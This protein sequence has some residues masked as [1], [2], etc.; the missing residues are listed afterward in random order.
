MRTTR[1]RAEAR[2]QKLDAAL[3]EAKGVRRPRTSD[4][5]QVTN[6]KQIFVTRHLSLVT[7]LSFWLLTSVVSAQQLST[8]TAPIFAVNAQYVQGVAPGYWPTA[9][10]GLVLNIA[11]GTATCNNAPANY[12]GGTLT[13]AANATN[14]VYLDPNSGCA[15]AYNTTGFPAGAQPIATVSTGASSIAQ[16]SDQRTWFAAGTP[17]FVSASSFPG[18]SVG[19]QIDAACAS[20]GGKAGAV[21]IP[22]GMGSGQSPAGLANGCGVLDLRGSG[23]TL[24][25]KNAPDYAFNENQLSTPFL[26]RT[27]WGATQPTLPK[28][29]EV[30]QVSGDY[31]TGGTNGAPGTNSKSNPQGLAALV[32][33]CT[34]AQLSGALIGASW[35]ASQGDCVA[36]SGLASSWDTMN[37]TGDEGIEGGRFEADQGSSEFTATIS[38]ISGNTINYTSPANENTRGEQ[39]F[40]VDTGVSNSKVYSIGTVSTI[41]GGGSGDITVTGSGVSWSSFGDGLHCFWMTHGADK[42][43]LSIR[44][45]FQIESGTATATFLTISFYIQNVAR[46]WLDDDTGTADSPAGTG[47]YN[48]APCSTVTGLG[49]TGSLTVAN[50]S[51]FVAGDSI[52]MPV[53]L[54][55]MLQGVMANVSTTL[56]NI[57]ANQGLGISNLSPFAAPATGG[58]P[59]KQPVGM[60]GN[61]SNADI[62]IYANSG[63]DRTGAPIPP[64]SYGIQFNSGNWATPFVALA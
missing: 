30:V 17:P 9:G 24:T 47:L 61:V 50:A 16:I 12:A 57:I 54:G 22:Y 41:G 44:H 28:T 6:D 11:S 26:F 32:I 48:I 53:G 38:S 52:F 40:L 25:A 7:A 8:Q 45:V 39:R 2:S 43:G 64:P 19:G 20:L 63:V 27:R 36:V 3:S 42:Y 23:S 58:R 46:P 60:V 14:Y 55:T 4:K 56:P 35:C 10:A 33:T 34:P 37:A 13:L 59:V 5:W 29:L 1:L 49:L 51:S 31:F 15:P 21:L 18:A 62:Q